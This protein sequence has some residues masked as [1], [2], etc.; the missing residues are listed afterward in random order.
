MELSEKER[1]KEQ[2]IKPWAEQG[3]ELIQKLRA[4]EK[5]RHGNS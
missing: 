1:E 2:K 3:W 5:K 4:E